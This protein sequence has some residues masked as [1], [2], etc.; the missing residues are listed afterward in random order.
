[1]NAEL[2]SKVIQNDEASVLELLALGAD[3]DC[4][5]PD[6][7]T[8]LLLAARGKNADLISILLT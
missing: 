3:P 2:I 7:C 4:P 5:G 8:P 6:D 1:M